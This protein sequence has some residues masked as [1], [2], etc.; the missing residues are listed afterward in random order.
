MPNCNVAPSSTSGVPIVSAGAA[1]NPTF[2]TAVVAGGGTG[3]TTQAA[4]S[5]VC[6]GTSTTNP[7][8]ATGPNS[9]SNAILFAQ[10]STALPV[11]TTTG[12]AYMTGISFDAGS[13]TLSSFEEGTWVPSLS[14]VGTPAGC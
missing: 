6:G 9:S 10:G 14:A 5:V 2:S 8:Q 4:Y 12:T 13:N 11:F 3:V 7:F 1:A